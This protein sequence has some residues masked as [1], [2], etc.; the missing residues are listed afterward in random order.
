[1]SAR[2]TDKLS[3]K[4]VELPHLVDD[5]Y[6]L[7]HFVI[8]ILNN[9]KEVC[10]FS[11]LKLDHSSKVT[12]TDLISI[13][14]H[15]PITRVFP[16]EYSIIFENSEGEYASLGRIAMT[17]GSTQMTAI[18]GGRHFDSIS[19]SDFSSLGYNQNLRKP[20]TD[21]DTEQVAELLNSLDL[22][23][24]AK[25]A[26]FQNVAG[27]DLLHGTYEYLRRVLGINE[28]QFRQVKYNIKHLKRV[29]C[30]KTEVFAKGLNNYGQLG[31]TDNAAKKNTFVPV[32]LP[33]SLENDF[34]TQLV[35]GDKYTVLV[36]QKGRIY[37]TG[38]Y[39]TSGSNRKGSAPKESKFVELTSAVNVNKKG[40]LKT[41]VAKTAFGK[42]FLIGKMYNKVP[43]EMME[44][45]SKQELKES[46]KKFPSADVVLES[47]A[48]SKKKK[49]YSLLYE[50]AILGKLEMSIEDFM[51]SEIAFHKVKEILHFGQ[52]VWNRE[53]RF[54]T[55]VVF[56]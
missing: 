35:S 25:C 2:Q 44:K 40:F 34:L 13:E 6:L 41:N 12:P 22:E 52:P 37:L 1:M 32:T 17:K 4:E 53:K 9:K 3:P 15:L 27:I 48:K 42:V 11:S 18:D 49:N 29:T 46:G 55:K 51:K 19:G 20:V 28:E 24:E 23:R 31:F 21:W 45:K 54:Y 7:E 38:N 56:G 47:L 43:Y 30:T 39:S 36:S 26:K 8:A 33:K 10:Y 50:D 16:S 14:V 5:F